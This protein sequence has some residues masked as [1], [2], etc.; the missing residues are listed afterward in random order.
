MKRPPQYMS[1]ISRELGLHPRSLYVLEQKRL[2]RG[3]DFP[4]PA[5]TLPDG[6][7]LYDPVKFNKWYKKNIEDHH[8]AK[9]QAS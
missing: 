9:G 5:M 2:A 8:S 6:K 1:T 7:R 3:A 4:Q